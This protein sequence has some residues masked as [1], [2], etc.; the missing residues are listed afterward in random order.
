MFAE[1][2]N[3]SLLLNRAWEGREARGKCLV[4]DITLA[5]EKMPPGEALENTGKLTAAVYQR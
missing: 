4:F 1:A 3:C 2:K 5:L